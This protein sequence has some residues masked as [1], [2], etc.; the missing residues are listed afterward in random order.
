MREKQKN[1]G[2]TL[3][4]LVITIIVLLI[5]AGI[6]IATLTGE[7]GILTQA[8]KAKEETEEAEKEE[9]NIL[10]SYENYINNAIGDVPQVNDSNPGVLEGTGTE[11][12]PF[13]INSIED[14]VVFSHNVRTGNKYD[15]MT[16]KLGTNLDFKSDKSY[17]DSDRTDYG[18][19]GYNGNLK[20]LLTTGEG[21]IP[22]GEQILEGENN[23]YGIFDGNNKAI[24][25]M[26]INIKSN[27]RVRAGLFS[28]NYGE[29]KNLGVVNV[30]I[31]AEGISTTS[32]GGIAAV[33]YNNIYDCYVTGNIKATGSYW[34]P[35]GG[36]CG[37]MQE[38][39]NI[40][41]CYNLAN[42]E[43][44]NIKKGWGD[45]DIGCGGIVGQGYANINKCY[46]KG[47]ILAKGGEN[48]VSIG[49]ICG[50][51][52]NGYIK[53]SYNTGKVDASSEQT[54]GESYIGGII[55]ASKAEYIINCYNS[56]NIMGDIYGAMIGGIL[57][58]QRI[59]GTISNI[60]NSRRNRDK[61]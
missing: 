11:Q 2:I 53:N 46:N 19:Y 4:S 55:G 32:A 15:G 9:R 52:D 20:Q 10:N 28:T 27:E 36:V 33:S 24:C 13:V 30:D 12:D 61:T 23:F 45:A 1:K 50:H 8:Q 7:N 43:C 31:T 60:Y 59:N 58:V 44:E 18:E 51:L 3:I 57:G 38:K 42:I 14:L 17:V 39:G 16:V 56:G 21:F 37:V 54:K 40:E 34:M 5:L 6:T 47:N 48:T 41:N 29:I 35:V 25:S 26:Y 22:I 49:G